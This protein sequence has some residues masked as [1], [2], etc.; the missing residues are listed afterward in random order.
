MAKSKKK[1]PVPKYVNDPS[2]Q[3][4][5]DIL[6][7]KNRNKNF[8]DRAVNPGDKPSIQ[9]NKLPGLQ[10]Q[11]IPDYVNSTHLMAHDLDRFSGK[12]RVY[13]MLVQKNPNEGLE[14]LNPV[15][16]YSYAD[17]SGEYVETP[18][19]PLAEYF[20]KQGYKMA[21]DNLY[22]TNYKQYMKQK[23]GGTIKNN[24]FMKIRPKYFN[25]EDLPVKGAAG[26]YM[27]P[28]PKIP[29]LRKTIADYY[30]PQGPETDFQ[31]SKIQG[32]VPIGTSPDTSKVKPGSFL[33]PEDLQP[34]REQGNFNPGNAALLAMGAF[35]ALLPN[36]VSKQTVVQPQMAYNPT[37]YGQG[38]QALMNYGGMMPSH[39]HQYDRWLT[40]F[41]LEPVPMAGM[42]QADYG[43][44]MGEDE[45]NSPSAK[46]GKTM[47]S[48]KK[49]GY[50][51]GG[52]IPDNMS[53][54]NPHDYEHGGDVNGCA[55]IKEVGPK[56]PNTDLME[57]WL[58]YE[59]GG[60]V[61]GGAKI[62]EV[63]PKFPNSDL[64]EQ[65]LLYASGGDVNGGAKVKDVGAMF[66]NAD[67][68]EQWLL[69]EN[70][71]S[72]SAAKAKEML[73]DG[74]AN[75]KKLTKKQKQYFGMVASGKAALGDMLTGD[76]VKPSP[77]EKYYQSSA[78]LS[79][80]K[81]LLN[82][83]LKAKN[84]QGFQDYFKGL[85]D[86]R[87][88]GD[89]TGASKYVQDAPY[90]D[91]LSPKEVQESLGE[92]YNDY[93][94]SIKDVNSYNVSQGQQPLYGNIEGEADINKLNYG[95]RFA[96]MQ[97]TPSLSAY[98][99][100][101]DTRYSREYKYNPDTKQVDFTETGDPKLRP[102]YLSDPNDRP[103]PTINFKDGG[104]M[105][106]DGGQIDTM[107]GGNAELESFN[108]YDGGTVEFNGASH[109]NG[110]IGMQYNGNPI[111]VEGGEY[112]SKD[113]EGNLHIYGNMFIPGSKTKFKKA[114][115]AIADKEKRYDFIKTKGSDLVNN[116]NPANRFDQLKFNAG[117]VMMQGGEMGQQDLA[118]KKER[119]ASIQKSML[120]MAEEHGLDPF[121]MSKG[122]MK[123]AKK[124]A[125]IPYAEN[126][127]P[128]END[129]T[130]ADRNMNPGNIKY[131]KF[132]KKYGAKRDKDGFAIFPNRQTGQ[133]AMQDLLTSPAY[134]NM[135]AKEAIR[136]WTGG[137]PYR[138]DLGPITDKK[139]AEMD[140]DELSIVM[141]TMT[142]GEGTRY[143]VT[144]RPAPKV[145]T[146]T[147]TPKIP[148]FTPYEVPDV[149]LTTPI[150]GTTPVKPGAPYDFL[151]VPTRN[152]IPSNVEPLGL[153][154]TLGEIYGAATNRVEP[155]PAQRYEPQLFTPY[156]VSFQDRLNANQSVFNAQQR[157]VGA[158][159]PAALG[160]LGAQKYAAD[161]ATY[162]DEFRANQA[163]AS[164]IT[165]KNIALVNDANL[166][167]LGIADTQMVRQ[168]QAR[169]K[170]REFNQMIL[171]SLS[172]KYA[173]N[174]L[175]NKRL[176]AYENLYDY[177]FVPT[178]DGGQQATYFGPNAMFNYSGKGTNQK[179]QDV[180]TITRY[181]AQGN[182]KGY[183]EYDESDL[184]EM[185]RIL[186]INNKKS[187]MG[188]IPQL[189]GK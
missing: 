65:W 30:G 9:T 99:K 47:K 78:R 188:L 184:K 100:A 32:I 181:D 159:N 12:G 174:E 72:L 88:K 106:D 104:I 82:D 2:L 83:K 136:K 48:K 120:E 165:N 105:Y 28:G 50:K 24:K 25:Y 162:A 13:P 39:G 73:K 43:Y 122:K 40:Q 176:A 22:G 116:A 143:G 128:G 42:P 74:K 168:S 183:A 19:H 139:I 69:Y 89:V 57:Q 178:D 152:P 109:D 4:L 157:A 123:K 31:P 16:A 151:E 101:K 14:Y 34:P 97:I 6:L 130:R 131:G 84:P 35:D 163:I 7:W 76:P 146:D 144:P 71:G 75:G 148:T 98:N 49:K 27:E 142:K 127:D 86:L 77:Q 121:E 20:S 154:N 170:T 52:I 66:P 189:Y 15:D 186:D 115:K 41:L 140:P 61:N 166:K 53:N 54:F 111:E 110:G 96:S 173:K 21:S 149:P 175:E 60:N 129:P 90:N 160:T 114:A 58:L 92:G 117:K 171:N 134:K 124:G 112:A 1:D 150:P 113:G 55:K 67:L 155:V 87:R 18:S 8:I 118:S 94:S 108:P 5:S 10:D 158:S 107:W 3:A 93:L 17:K 70:G 37:P 51:S 156:Q 36:R 62:K 38:S 102:S 133:K 182:K 44:V 135:S 11:N 26:M 79:Y 103:M 132:A 161:S 68:M 45:N 167:N 172:D 177:R 33:G 185:Q 179:A 141:G 138:Y 64:L 91:Y 137:N 29:G 187:K 180:R 63:G 95:R 23:D 147:P 80:Y 153:N 169:S 85:V 125:S 126:G 81:N 119:L 164:D 56:Y 59:Q 145:P 46:N